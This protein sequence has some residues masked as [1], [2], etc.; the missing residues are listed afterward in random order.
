MNTLTLWNKIKSFKYVSF[1]IFDTLIKR[2]VAIPKDVFMYVEDTYNSVSA[3]PISFYSQR[4]EA[5]R[6]VRSH[7]KKED[8]TLDEIYNQIDLTDKEKKIL[9]EI[10]LDTEIRVCVPNYQMRHIFEKCLDSGKKVI[11]ISDMYLPEDIISKILYKNGYRGYYKL[12]LSS[13]IGLRKL[14]GNLFQYVLDDLQINKNDI[15]HIGDSKRADILACWKKGIKTG[16]IQRNTVNTN[17][18][19]AKDIYTVKYSPYLFVNNIIPKYSDNTEMFQWGY[20]AFGPM[21][22]GFCRWIHNT[23]HENKIEQIFFLAR[24]MYLVIKIYALLYPQEHVQYLEVSR[25]SLRRAYVKLAKQLSAV[26]DTISRGTYSI[27]TICESLEL[28]TDKILFDCSN[29]GVIFSGSDKFPSFGTSEYNIINEVIMRHLESLDECAYKY[30]D[31]MGVTHNKKTAIVDIGWHCALQNM[32]EKISGKK[33]IGLYF[34]SAIRETFDKMDRYGYW[35]YAENESSAVRQMS[36]ANFLETMLLPNIGTVVD[37]REDDEKRIIPIYG[38]CEM[39]ET[40]KLVEEFQQGAMQFVLDYTESSPYGDKPIPSFIAVSAFEKLAFSPTLHQAK[41]MS[42]L[43]FDNLGVKSIAEARSIFFYL[44]HP[45]VLLLDY[46]RAQWH[47]GF[48][49]QILPII[50][51]PYKFEVVAKKLYKILKN[52]VRKAS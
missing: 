20:E 4:I 36:I 42:L 3:F 49:K 25:K 22:L 51:S 8:V 38:M 6:Y 7:A 17:F 35:F 5:E 40:Y 47:A 32:L 29:N 31:F 15:I 24:D 43:K 44:Q 11:I 9:K 27:C 45:Q 19:G 26:F 33:V 41:T 12:Y 1:D 16:Y 21:L 52:I 50:N 46:K 2:N 14:S 10:E 23:V 30:L 18:V 39:D 34:G 13:T 28:D 37:Y 48:I